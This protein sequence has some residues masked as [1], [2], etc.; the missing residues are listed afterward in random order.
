MTIKPGRLGWTGAL[1]AIDTAHSLGKLWRASGLLETG[2]GRSFTN[3]L[4]VREDAFTSDVAP[5]SWFFEDDV[6][7][8]AD[9]S[10]DAVTIVDG[11]GIGI[12]PDPGMLER[13]RVAT[14]ELGA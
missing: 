13:Y 11:A 4:A 6:V 12:A 8:S 3:H 5:A 10:G 14:Y 7:H 2:I 9:V 1:Q